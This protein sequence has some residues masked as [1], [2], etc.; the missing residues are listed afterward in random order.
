VRYTVRAFNGNFSSTFTASN[1]TKF[2]A[3]PAVKVAKTT[4]GVKASW[5]KSAGATGYIVYRRTYSNGKWSGWTQIKTTTALSYTDTTAKKGVTYQ[6]TARAYSGD[7]RSS[8]TNSASI[9]R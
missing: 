3:Q 4:T 6:Y 9:K 2:L 1:T 7:Y 5:V 8:Y